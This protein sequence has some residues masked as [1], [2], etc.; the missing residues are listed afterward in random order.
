[1]R[2][3]DALRGA[4]RA[5]R[6]EERSRLIPIQTPVDFR[7][8]IGA[9]Q[10]AEVL[11]FRDRTAADHVDG[12]QVSPLGS[13]GRNPGEQL[14]LADQDARFAVIENVRDQ[15]RRKPD[16]Q[17]HRDRAQDEAGI[18]AKDDF[19]AVRQQKRDAVAG[20]NPP[21]GQRTRHSM[22]QSEKIGVRAGLIADN[23]RRVVVMTRNPISQNLCKHGGPPSR[24]R[25]IGAA[26]APGDHGQG[27]LPLPYAKTG[28]AI[29]SRSNVLSCAC[30]IR[31]RRTE[32]RWPRADAR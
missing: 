3:N 6:V 20:L 19:Q 16:V 28:A 29:I 10:I 22:A 18:V 11:D 23:E 26:T 9:Q 2:V 24:P 30:R 27:D 4:G 5:R 14:G 32:S 17:R 13:D 12:F 8:D 7:G 31:L 15:L 21:L 25:R 1:M